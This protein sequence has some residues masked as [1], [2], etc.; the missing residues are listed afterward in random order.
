MTNS[1]FCSDE[2]CANGGQALSRSPR[3]CLCRGKIP[4]YYPEQPKATDSVHL[5]WKCSRNAVVGCRWP[6]VVVLCVNCRRYPLL[7][8]VALIK[9]SAKDFIYNARILDLF[10]CCLTVRQIATNPQDVRDRLYF[11]PVTVQMRMWIFMYSSVLLF[12]S[13]RIPI[14]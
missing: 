12:A 9:N 10:I 4:R 14:D 7:N 11:F 1:Y 13:R 6:V 5:A 2:Y 8:H 3:G